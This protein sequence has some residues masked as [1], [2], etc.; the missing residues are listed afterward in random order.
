M[1]YGF[2]N[3]AVVQMQNERRTRNQMTCKQEVRI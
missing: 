3:L 2:N 1:S